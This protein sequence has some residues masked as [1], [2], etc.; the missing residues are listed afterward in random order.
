EHKRP[1]GAEQVDQIAYRSKHDKQQECTPPAQMICEPPARV[2][3]DRVEEILRRSKQSDR[4]CPRA[5]RLKVARQK[6]L[7]QLL[8]E[9]E[10]EDGRGGRQDVTLHGELSRD[11]PSPRD[12]WSN[13]LL[14]LWNLHRIARKAVSD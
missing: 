10:Q 5:E 13:A 9:K 12:R 4:H 7:P 14:I 6:L 1:R 3:I 11:P 2:L 8:T